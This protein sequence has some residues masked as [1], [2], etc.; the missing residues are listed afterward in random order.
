MRPRAVP[1]VFGIA[2]LVG[3][4]AGCRAGS[5]RLEG[6]WHGV[7]AEGVSGEALASANAFAARME[8][9]VSG[10]TLTITSP[11]ESQSGRYRVVHEDDNSVTVTTDKDG[12]DAPQTFTFAGPT[13]LKWSVLAGKSIVFARPSP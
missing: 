3:F 13:T 5:A 8:L 6:R 4:G 11:G 7:R 1:R 10:D 12:T 2:V 9:E